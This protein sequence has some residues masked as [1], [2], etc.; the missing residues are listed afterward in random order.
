MVAQK[1]CDVCLSPRTLARVTLHQGLGKHSCLPSTGVGDMMLHRILQSLICRGCFGKPHKLSNLNWDKMRVM[2]PPEGLK[3]FKSSAVLQG[4]RNASMLDPPVQAALGQALRDVADEVHIS[5]YTAS[6]IT[7]L[8]TFCSCT[9]RVA[10]MWPILTSNT[11]AKASKQFATLKQ[12]PFW[13][14]SYRPLEHKELE[15]RTG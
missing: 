8:D 11:I 4:S 2:D 1:S 13:T 6:D 10:K 5:C 9:L 12:L 7:L 15:W 14:F 3:K